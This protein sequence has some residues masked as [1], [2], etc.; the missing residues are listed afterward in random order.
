MIY[1]FP[2]EVALDVFDAANLTELLELRKCSAILA[3]NTHRCIVSK[4][5]DTKVSISILIS[6]TSAAEDSQQTVEATMSSLTLANQT[7]GDWWSL[8]NIHCTFD[9]PLI[10]IPRQ[11]LHTASPP[12]LAVINKNTTRI[13]KAFVIEPDLITCDN[14]I[15]WNHSFS[16]AQYTYQYNQTSGD[17]I[18][19]NL[20]LVVPY[21]HLL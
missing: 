13:L 9:I 8:D 16:D 21:S 3:R 15:T 2:T 12:R 18:L 4:L 14:S 5:K 11:T 7:E 20:R 19:S 1:N 10:T 17:G 6:F